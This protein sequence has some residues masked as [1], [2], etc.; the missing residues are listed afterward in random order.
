MT[1]MEITEVPSPID[2]RL[3][4]DASAWE[5]KAMDRPFRQDFFDAFT[6]QLSKQSKDDLSILELGSGPGFLAAYILDRLPLV[7]MSLLDFSSSMH[8]L[9]QRRL[10]AY[11][12]RTTFIM[13]NFKESNWIE[14]LGEFDAI[15]TLQAVHE[16]RHKH[17]AEKFH[18]QA[19]ELLKANGHYLVCDH[20]F[21]E[22]AMKNDQLF[23]SLE[24]QRASLKNSGYQITDVL[25]KGGRALYDA[26]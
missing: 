3:M 7:R 1:I 2:L 9:A 16:L 24:E 10:A 23:M 8:S 25:I 18:R 14:G 22:N 6:T 17:Y 11:S 26:T 20:Y 5:M 13:R 19:K 21:G 12:D 4:T 15:I